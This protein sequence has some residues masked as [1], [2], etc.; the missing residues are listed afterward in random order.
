MK[1]NIIIIGIIVWLLAT[2]SY[3]IYDIWNDYKINGVEKA[4]E[5]GMAEMATKTI[6][7]TENSSCEAIPIYAGEKKTTIVSARCIPTQE[8]ITS[9]K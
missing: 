9:K 4:Y 8:E 7:A 5:A 6:E 3:V 2:T 1:K